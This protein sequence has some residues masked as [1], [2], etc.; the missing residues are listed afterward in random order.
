MKLGK[1]KHYKG[2]YYEV[3]GEAVH[4]ETREELVVYRM[5]YETADFPYGALWVR[6]KS[7][8]LGTVIHKE[9]EVPRFQYVEA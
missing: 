3:I 2:Q 4:T 6:P 9:Q 1:Y 5:L 8:F 7:M